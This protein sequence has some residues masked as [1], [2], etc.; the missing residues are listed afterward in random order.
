[1][2]TEADQAE[3]IAIGEQMEAE[4]AA[5]GPWAQV[6]ALNAPGGYHRIIPQNDA[7]GKP[8]PS[9]GLLLWLI[10][11][12]GHRSAHLLRGAPMPFLRR[13]W[14]ARGMLLSQFPPGGRVHG[15]LQTR[16]RYNE[17][18]EADRAQFS[19]RNSPASV[20]ADAEGYKWVQTVGPSVGVDPPKS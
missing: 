1:M 6:R 11:E 3:D 18:F 20:P 7:A 10:D 12:Q 19:P 17:D 15:I 16:M 4:H 13:W 9:T 14:V 8:V 2:R 5:R